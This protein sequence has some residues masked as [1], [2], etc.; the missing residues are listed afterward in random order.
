LA[1]VGI[2]AFWTLFPYPILESSQLRLKLADTVRLLTELHVRTHLEIYRRLKQHGADGD[3]KADGSNAISNLQR[4]YI[5]S[6]SEIQ[7]LLA[8]SKYQIQLG[9]RFSQELYAALL[10]NVD[11]VFRS[12]SLVVYAAR[13]FDKLDEKASGSPWM[14]ELRRVATR[15]E[16]NVLRTVSVLSICA[17]SIHRAHPLPPVLDVPDTSRLLAAIKTS[18]MELLHVKYALE[19][20]YS[21]LAAIHASSSVVTDEVRELVRVT[22]ELVGSMEFPFYAENADH[23]SARKVD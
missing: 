23:S 12:L 10:N 3:N 15:N 18:P 19:P 8:N 22:A 2:A 20:G 16:E 21:A 1:G 4:T 17:E 6:L 5:R 11:S 14:T 9:G 13:S 7:Q